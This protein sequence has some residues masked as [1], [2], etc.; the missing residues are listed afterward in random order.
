MTVYI[1]VFRAYDPL[2]NDDAF[3]PEYV[4]LGDGEY[5]DGNVHF[6]TCKSQERTSDSWLLLH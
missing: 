3:D 1:E 2:N 5:A 4:V 6:N